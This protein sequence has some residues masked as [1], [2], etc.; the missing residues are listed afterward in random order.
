MS[1]I[2]VKTPVTSNGINPILDEQG[3]IVYKETVMEI[4]AKPILEKINEKLPVHLR[5][6]ITEI[7]IEK[8]KYKKAGDENPE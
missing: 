1:E 8:R 3:Q 5:K 6:I 2:L 7:V 4:A